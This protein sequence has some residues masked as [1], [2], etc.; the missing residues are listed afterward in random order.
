M[1]TIKELRKAKNLSRTRVAADLDMSERHLHR[2]ETGQSP[3][4]RVLA[5]AFAD[6]YGIPVEKIDHQEEVVA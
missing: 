6:Y 1:P 3:L 2:L 4:R 5:H